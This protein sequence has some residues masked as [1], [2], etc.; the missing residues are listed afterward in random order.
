MWKFSTGKYVV[1]Y[2]GP[3]FIN[4][5]SSR[6]CKNRSLTFQCSL[7]QTEIVSHV[8]SMLLTLSRSCHRHPE[9]CLTFIGGVQHHF[10]LYL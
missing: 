8:L 1:D 10:V 3:A 9:M 2:N 6:Q 7:R 5:D 4:V